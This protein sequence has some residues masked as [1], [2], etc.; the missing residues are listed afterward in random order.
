MSRVIYSV[1]PMPSGRYR[2]QVF[3]DG[4]PCDKQYFATYAEAARW[5]EAQVVALAAVVR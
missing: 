3:V 2:A 4:L 5:G 1:T